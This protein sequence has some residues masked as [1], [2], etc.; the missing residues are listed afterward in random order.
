MIQQELSMKTV[1]SLAFAFALSAL[2]ALQSGCDKKE[3]N[4]AATG[5]P[6][7][8][9]VA[10]LPT[11]LFLTTEPKDAKPVEDAKKAAKPGETI[12]VRGR[13]GGSADPF[14]AGRTVFTIVGPGLKSCAENPGDSCKTPWD[15]CCEST[16]DIA[17]HAATVQVVDA[18]G[19]PVKADIKGQSGVK[20]LTDVI[21]VGK[22]AQADGKVLV[23]NA[24]GIYVAS[25]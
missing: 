22:V 20:E 14:V 15:Y 11:G 17:A 3:A 12:V 23:V 24:T 7:G 9:P 19:A 16:E 6:T 25:N 21:V 5:K 13:V 18:A 4:P 2:T 1:R 8:S 10:V